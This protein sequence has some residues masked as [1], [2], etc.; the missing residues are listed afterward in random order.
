MFRVGR[1]INFS[2]GHRLM[3]YDGKC[4]HLHGHNG[5]VLIEISSEKLNHQGMVMD[6]Y[7]IRET[8][9]VWIQEPLDHRTILWDKDPL[10]EPLQKA[11]EPVVLFKENPNP[12]F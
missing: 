10:A 4:A 8:I 6:F 5:R 11:G 3:D 9:G 1:E 12:Q 7:K 2:Y